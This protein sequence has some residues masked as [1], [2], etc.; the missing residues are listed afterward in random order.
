M[1]IFRNKIQT[2]GQPNKEANLKTHMNNTEIKQ[3][4]KVFVPE[5]N[6]VCGFPVHND[7]QPA[8]V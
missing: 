4:I 6:L 3:M 1:A 5:N 8:R 2:S 7:R